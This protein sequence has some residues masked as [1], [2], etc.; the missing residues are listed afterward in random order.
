[1]PAPPDL[2]GSDDPR[3]ADRLASTLDLDLRS[4]WSPTRT[5]YLGKVSKRHVLAAVAEVAGEAKARAWA[6]LKKEALIELAEPML[7]E[8]RWLPEPLRTPAAATSDPCRPTAPRRG[9]ERT[10]RSASRRRDQGRGR[11]RGRL[12]GPRSAGRTG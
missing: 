8:A 6:G 4:C 11:R 9:R 1:M 5:A 7:T 2:P 10:F 3:D 12:V